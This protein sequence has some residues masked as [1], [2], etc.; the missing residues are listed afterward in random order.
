MAISWSS[1][2]PEWLTPDIALRDWRR[3][4]ERVVEQ[5]T[6]YF[7]GLPYVKGLALTGSTAVGD[8]WPLSDVDLFVV[9]CP[10]EGKKPQD[11]VF[12]ARDQRNER[13]ESLRIPNPVEIC[14]NMIVSPEQLSAAA[15]N[16]D[17]CFFRNVEQSAWFGAVRGM[18]DGGKAVLDPS[19]ELAVF[20]RRCH[21]AGVADRLVREGVEGAMA[22]VRESLQAASDM[23]Q[24]RNLPDASK[25]IICAAIWLI[26]GVY[27]LWCKAPRSTT[28]GIARLIQD[29]TEADD[30]EIV[31]PFLAAVRLGEEN[32]WQ[33][34][35]QVAECGRAERD[36][37]LAVRRGAG[38]TV[39]EL[40]ATRDLLYSHTERLMWRSAPSD[41]PAWSGV[42]DDETA[43]R[44]QL[45]AAED[46]V[47]WLGQRLESL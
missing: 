22:T 2:L 5:E 21:Q 33:R 18:V 29:A 12:A 30:D 26:W 34:F 17:E 47:S 19:G 37:V 24:D 11:L 3:R 28:R 7:A 9:A 42:T 1:L 31:A 40:T 4:I 27:G 10:W 15:C 20:L 45:A 35:A 43:V 13:L 23:V 32:T 6:A 16:D 39:D 44:T 14:D 41:C 46:L 36:L 25:K 38:E 8:P